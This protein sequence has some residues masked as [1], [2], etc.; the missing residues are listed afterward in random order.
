MRIPPD[1]FVVI[2]AFWQL[3][4][5]RYVF[6]Q[7]DL[8]PDVYLSR[9]SR[10]GNPLVHRVLL[11]FERL[12]CRLADHVIAT[13]ESYKRIDVECSGIEAGRITV[14]RN[15]PEQWHFQQYGTDESLRGNKPIVIGYVGA[16]CRQDGIDCLLRSLNILLHEYGRSDWRCVLI[17]KGDSMEELKQWRRSFTSPNCFIL[18][19]GWITKRFPIYRIDGHLRHARPVEHVQRSLNHC[20]NNGIHGPGQASGG[21]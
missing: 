10:P 1:F 11:F 12:S 8:A 17:G 4:G 21:I 16:M 18:Q 5:K 6:D 9:F 20:E 15:G 7:H 3:F 19:A 14:V 2:G 13:N